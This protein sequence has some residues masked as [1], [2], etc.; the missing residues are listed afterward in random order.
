MFV[1][2][3]DWQTLTDKDKLDMFF[4]FNR[5]MAKKYPSS[6]QKFN[7]KGT[8]LVVA[9]DIWF[10]SLRRQ[11][12]VPKWFWVG[13]KAPSKKKTAASSHADTIAEY[14][15]M[16]V[17]DAAFLVRLYGADCKAECAR[18]EKIRKETDK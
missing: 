12:G 1:R 4:M 2:K 10:A 5:Y 17:I 7:K 3:S 14:H 9:L 13:A 11:T 18:I 6:A 16:S 8:D 15:G